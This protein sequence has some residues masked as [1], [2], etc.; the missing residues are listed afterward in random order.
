MRTTLNLVTRLFKREDDLKE[1]QV[2]QVFQMKRA[3]KKNTN[4]HNCG[5]KGHWWAECPEPKKP[6]K[7]SLVRAEINFNTGALSKG[8][9]NA[10]VVDSE[11][12]AHMS[13]SEDWFADFVPTKPG[14][15]CVAGDGHA[16]QVQGKGVVYLETSR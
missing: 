12:T 10:W 14:E 15:T 9:K 1:G 5:K 2:N 13:N 4:C 6:K 16:L 3:E 11:V 7:R 8:L